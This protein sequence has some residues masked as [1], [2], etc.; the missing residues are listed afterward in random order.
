MYVRTSKVVRRDVNAKRKQTKKHKN[1]TLRISEQVVVNSTTCPSCKGKNLVRGLKYRDIG[2]LPPQVKRPRAKRAFDLV[3]SPSGIRRK[4]IQCQTSFH[5]CEDC[6]DVFVPWRHQ[7]LA[8]HFHGLMSWVMYQH[9]AHRISMKKIEVMLREFFGLQVLDGEIARIKSQMAQ[10]YKS[11][12][13]DLL[14]RLLS[15]SVLHVDETEIKLRNS[16]AYVWVFANME[17]V[18]Y[19]HRPTRQ[20]HFLK[21]MLDSFDGV[22]VTDFYSAYDSLNCRQQKCLI[23]LMRDMNQEL[24]ANPFDKELQSVTQPFGS[25]LRSAVESIDKHGLKRRYL[26]KHDWEIGKFFADLDQMVLVS[27]AA[28]SLQ[29]RLIKNRSKLFTFIGADGVSWNNNCAENAIKHFAYYRHNHKGQLT[30]RGLND[31]LVLLSLFQTCRYKGV[32]FLR[33]MLSKQRLLL[34]PFKRKSRKSRQMKVEVYP[35]GFTPLFATA[36]GSSDVPEHD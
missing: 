8:K 10:Y 7:R 27:D 19:M 34:H 33:F 32:S 28:K 22:L 9:V 18:V 30:E 2:N 31:Y 15:G 20:A 26:K 3:V 36:S 6:G 14:R 24:L 1:A 5:R 13:R 25:L 16:K 35:K 12:Y 29:E 23:H 4:V 17:E 21:K 11:T